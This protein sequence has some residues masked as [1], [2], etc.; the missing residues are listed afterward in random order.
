L[1]DAIDTI[2]LD[3]SK[4]FDT[5]PHRRLIQKLECYGITGKLLK[6]I[7]SFL[8]NR[9]QRVAL[10]GFLS[11]WKL[12]L[13]GVP[14]GSVL[15]PFLFVIFINDLQ[16]VLKVVSKMYADDTK[17]ISKLSSPNSWMELQRDLDNACEWSNK[18]LLEFNVS[19]CLVMHYG[20]NNQRAK[21]VMNGLELKETVCERD[22]GVIF[23]TDLKWKNHVTV[24]ESKANQ[25]LGM[26]K[27]TFASMDLRLL[28]TL[29][30]TFVRPLIEFA[31][32]VWSPSLK[33][34]KDTIERIQ[35]RATRMVKKL[36]ILPYDER[37]RKLG[38]VTLEQRRKRG[39]LIQVFKMFNK[40][41]KIKLLKEPAFHKVLR[42]HKRC[43]RREMSK[44]GPRQEFLTNR[45]AN[46]WN[47]LK[48]ESVNAESI[49]EF[50]RRIDQEMNDL[51]HI[52]K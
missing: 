41:E 18:W 37:L 24:C 20:A 23:S 43:Y 17:L 46:D 48:V 34:D 5:V 3:F 13:S 45:T 38:I 44:F 39:D 51:E 1:G 7:K 28:R 26:V 30:V 40:Y 4:A 10:N 32:P 9:K 16:D 6:W 12:V 33:G 22:L 15:G 25:M 52:Y 36:R 21:Y 2:Y 50:K 19:K 49:N 42:G 35:H 27:R 47:A 29:Y 14:Q 8:T 31:A 11:M